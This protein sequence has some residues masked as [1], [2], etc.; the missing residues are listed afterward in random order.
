MATRLAP[1]HQEILAELPLLRALSRSLTSSPP[2][3]DD[4]VQE[5][6]RKAI[7]NIDQFSPGTNLRAWLCRILRN[8]F[9]TNYQKKVREPR[10]EVEELPGVRIEAAQEWTLKLRAVDR[11][12]HQLPADQREAV[13]LV[14]GAGLSYEEAAEACDC[15]LGTIKSRVSRGRN[16]LLSLL[17]ASDAREFLDEP[18]AAAVPRILPGQ[19]SQY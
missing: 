17:D 13:M 16:T 11:A 18:E 19:A 9:C 7:A 8:T 14:G 12:L 6:L 1:I 2:E 4:L 3:A 10:L 5:T 15:A